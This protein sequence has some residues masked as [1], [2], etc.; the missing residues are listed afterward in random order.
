M[1]LMDVDPGRSK[2]S[3]GMSGERSDDEPGLVVRLAPIWDQ[4]D[5]L[6]Q[7][8]S[9]WITAKGSKDSAERAGLV[10]QELLENAV[11]YG[12][13]KSDV[14]VSISMSRSGQS[15]D[16]RVK[17]WAHPSRLAILEREISRNRA[18]D[19]REA[20]ARALERLNRLPE[21]SSMLGLARVGL[22]SNLDVQIGPGF[23]VTTARILVA[24]VQQQSSRAPRGS[25][26]ARSRASRCRRT[27]PAA[28]GGWSRKA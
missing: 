4:I 24:G 16:I 19:P 28:R 6:R 14:E 25:A 20:F 13:P 18:N 8:V 2:V 27:I 23:V 10:V 1:P 5:P 22:E 9:V 7:Y 15:I 21:G 3:M 17:N 11:K 26:A 12:D